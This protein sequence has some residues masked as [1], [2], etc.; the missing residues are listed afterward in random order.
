MVP[1][2]IDVLV[3][4]GLTMQV[5]QDGSSYT[6]ELARHAPTG[7][8]IEDEQWRPEEGGGVHVDTYLHATTRSQLEGT[9]TRAVTN[10]WRPPPGFEIGFERFGD[11]RDPHWRTL[12]IASA[13]A[14]DGT[15]IASARPSNDPNTG[16]PIVLLDFTDDGGR[17][18][19]E[20]TRRIAGQKL[21]TVLGGRI[22][23][24]P[25]INGPICGGRAAITMGGS[26]VLEQESERDMLASVLS[27]GALPRGGSVESAR[28]S[29]P[30]D[31]AGTEWAGRLLLGFVVGSAAVLLV[32]LVLG[33]VRPHRA[34]RPERVDGAFPLRRL[35][36]T[37][38]GPLALIAGGNIA[39]PGLDALELK[40]VFASA[41]RA[42]LSVITLGVMPILSAFVLVELVAL[43]FPALRWRR[44]DPQGR[45]QLGQAAAVLACLMALVQ[46]FFA[47]GY[48]EQLSRGGPNVMAARDWEFRILIMVT[49]ATGSMLLGVLAGL[50]SEYGLGNGYGLRLR[51][52]GEREVALRV[53][54]SGVIPLGQAGGLLAAISTLGALGLPVGLGSTAGRML[55][56]INDIAHRTW[57]LVVL[58]AVLAWLWSWLWSWL[59][60]HPSL[61]APAARQAGF[62]P[63]TR[64]SWRR[65]ALLSM[66]AVVAVAA[67]HALAITSLPESVA[68]ANPAMA[69]IATAVVLDVIDDARARRGVLAPAAV[70]HRIQLADVVERA[71][72]EADIPCHIHASNLR[73]LMAFFGP[74]APAIVLVP[75]ALAEEAR[76]KLDAILRGAVLEPLDP[77]DSPGDILRASM[78][79]ASSETAA[80]DNAPARAAPGSQ[81]APSTAPGREPTD[82]G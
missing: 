65:A 66:A 73:T 60:S 45:V 3:G 75:A 24:A 69:M 29:P 25:I 18:F 19:C 64:R 61:V 32:G 80:P 23:S 53:P 62:N 38:L 12:L 35:A 33:L 51:I 82:A 52:G 7:V 55:A 22:R 76:R 42:D 48:L 39:L 68:L 36:V 10:G 30:A 58:T 41:A 63:V 6:R 15:M 28:W 54:T 2:L 50:I 4:G 8:E 34:G 46:G 59:L 21:A 31:I 9:V 1:E 27:R 57:P 71:L 14:I 44:H 72:A 11:Q 17:K 70:L 37:M 56:W 47:A 5:V 13:A 74:W 81:P 40:R 20:L 49:L 26:D 77:P 67:L 16:R 79:H 78:G 43:G